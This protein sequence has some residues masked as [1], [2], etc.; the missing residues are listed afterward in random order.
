[1]T[2]DEA[3][4][5]LPEG[6]WIRIEINLRGGIDVWLFHDRKGNDYGEHGSWQANVRAAVEYAK[7]RAV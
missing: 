4:K 2:L 6:W 3:L 5:Q 1:M 7:E